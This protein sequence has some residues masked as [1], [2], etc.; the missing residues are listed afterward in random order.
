[1]LPRKHPQCS[2]CK[3]YDDLLSMD[4]RPSYGL[5]AFAI[6]QGWYLRTNAEVLTCLNSRFM[7]DLQHYQAHDC[8][9]V[10]LHAL[11]MLRSRWDRIT[12]IEAVRIRTTSELIKKV[13]ERCSPP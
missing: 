5:A 13:E 7:F 12:I 2:R 11:L 10:T 6:G 4:F 3:T 1:M 8:P 9:G